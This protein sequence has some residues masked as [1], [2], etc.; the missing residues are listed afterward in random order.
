MYTV[1]KQFRF[2]AWHQLPS[3]DGQCR[4]RHGHSYRV[5]VGLSRTEV[6]LAG[7]KSGMVI[8]FGDLSRW[9]KTEMEGWLDHNDAGLNGVLPFD[10][11]PSTAENVAAFIYSKLVAFVG[12]TWKYDGDARDVRPAFVRVWETESAYAEYRL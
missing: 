3:H 11:Q 4:N 9:W 10:Y 7:P 5:E 8:D 2:E 6:D 1:V 12:T